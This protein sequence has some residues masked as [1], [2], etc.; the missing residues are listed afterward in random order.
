MG[1]NNAALRADPFYIGLHR[2][3]LTGAAYDALIDEFMATVVKRY[4]E[5]TL[6]QFED[7][8]NHNAHRLLARYRRRFCTFNDD[9]QG[10]AAVSLAGLLTANRVTGQPL[11]EQRI[12]FMGAGSAAEGIAHLLVEQMKAEGAT[13]SDALSRIS[14]FDIDGLLTTDRCPKAT[15]E[16]YKYSKAGPPTK[17]LQVAV[18]R[19]R[20]TALIGVSAVAGAFTPAILQFMAQTNLRPLIFALSNPTAMSEC[21]AEEAYSHT[22]GRAL[23]ASGSPFASVSFNGKTFEPGQCNN[24]YIFPAVALAVMACGVRRISDQVFIEAA[25]ALASEVKQAELEAGRLYPRLHQIRP[26]TLAIGA[27]LAEW[28]YEQGQATVYP[29]PANKYDFLKGLQY[30]P[31]YDDQPLKK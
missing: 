15:G 30:E 27:K 22:N 6:V 17:D 21:T 31:L 1:T 3:R 28:F 2:E 7:F 12:L 13:E 10:T 23:F 5:D 20:P 18:E 19:L 14:M 16:K 11:R 29:E 8:A 9:I 24:A 4:G 26:V 25:K